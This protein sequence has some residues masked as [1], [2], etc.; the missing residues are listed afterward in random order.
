MTFFNKNEDELDGEAAGSKIKLEPI[1][2]AH[3]QK[4]INDLKT[5]WKMW[6]FEYSDPYIHTIYSATR[7]IGD[8]LLVL[9]F[10]YHNITTFVRPICPKFTITFEESIELNKILKQAHRLKMNPVLAEQA[11]ERRLDEEKG[12]ED[13]KKIAELL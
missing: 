12:N 5:N 1:V 4:I 2:S 11:E 13:I 6:E 7:V 9:D 10:Q 3:V 8:F